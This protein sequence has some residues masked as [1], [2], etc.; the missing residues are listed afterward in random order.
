MESLKLKI[1]IELIEIS[2]VVFRKNYLKVGDFNLYKQKTGYLHLK[3]HQ[4]E[5]LSFSFQHKLK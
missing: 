5:K 2:F 3:M 1:N 4:N